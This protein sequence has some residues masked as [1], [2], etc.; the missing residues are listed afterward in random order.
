MRLPN[1]RNWNDNCQ[2]RYNFSNHGYR[3]VGPHITNFLE[4]LEGGGVQDAGKLLL[5]E[6]VG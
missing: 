4:S 6:G 3:G 5:D 2:R 1:S